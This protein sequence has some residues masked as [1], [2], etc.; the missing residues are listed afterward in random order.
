MQ[1]IIVVIAFL[2]CCVGIFLVLKLNKKVISDDIM[3]LLVEKNSPRQEVFL[4][5]H[6]AKKKKLKTSLIKLREALLMQGRG[7][8]FAILCMVAIVLA[9]LGIVIAIFIDN[10]YLTV[11]LALIFGAIPFFYAESAIKKYDERVTNELETALSIIT[12]AYIRTDDIVSAVEENLSYIAPPLDKFFRE[13]VGECTAIRS[14]NKKAIW[15]LKSKIDNEI[16]AEWCDSLISCQ[17]DRTLKVTLLPIVSKMTDVRI[18]NE[19]LK[20]MVAS[21]RVQYYGMT[22][23]SLGSIPMLYLL[24]KDWF[25]T[26]VTTT[27]GK[28][29]LAIVF[30]LV[31]IT[32]IFLQ[33]FSKPIQYRQ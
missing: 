5:Q 11:P 7:Q 23:L 28:I 33:K 2:L 16:F 20:T 26:L 1:N 32:L 31:F 24:N 13:F 18:V 10:P 15:N 29:I 30:M 4:R 17:D 25:D 27:P 6:K 21:A 3:S 19:E 14:D 12:T 8:M 9:I 22:G